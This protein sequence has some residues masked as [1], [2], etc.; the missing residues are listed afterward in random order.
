M[1]DE[2]TTINEGGGGGV[3]QLVSVSEKTS[4]VRQNL[5]TPLRHINTQTTD[6]P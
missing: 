6:N 1:R 2:V 5:T 4:L 3:G